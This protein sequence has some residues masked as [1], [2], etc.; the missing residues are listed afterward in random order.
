MSLPTLTMTLAPSNQ[1]QIKVFICG[2][3]IGDF[4]GKSIHQNT[5]RIVFLS[6]SLR[7]SNSIIK[8][9][10]AVFAKFVTVDLIVFG[11]L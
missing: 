6:C 4:F 1:A 3:N 7:Y 8:S 10:L 5:K 9:D 2:S 11:E